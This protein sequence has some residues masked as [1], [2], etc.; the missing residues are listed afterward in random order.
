MKRNLVA[1]TYGRFCI[2]FPQSRA[3]SLLR[4]NSCFVLFC[5]LIFFS[6]FVCVFGFFSI[7]PSTFQSLQS[8]DLKCT[9]WGLFQKRVLHSIFD[10]YV[11]IIIII[12]L[13]V[14]GNVCKLEVV[15]PVEITQ[16][17]VN[18]KVCTP[19]YMF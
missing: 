6:L 11:F 15:I 18:G 3:S 17:T 9:W 1:R 7:I 2:N 12:K 10:I 19:I 5:F 14:F 16:I 13:N 4:K 8:F